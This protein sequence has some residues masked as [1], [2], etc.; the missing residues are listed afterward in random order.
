ME[1]ELLRYCTLL[2][3]VLPFIVYLVKI[4]LHL[5]NVTFSLILLSLFLKDI[6]HVSALFICRILPKLHARWFT[7]DWSKY[8]SY[9]A[10]NEFHKP[11]FFSSLRDLCLLPDMHWTKPSSIFMC[12]LN[13]TVLIFGCYICVQS[14][15]C[16]YIFGDTTSPARIMY[17]SYLLIWVASV[18][19]KISFCISAILVKG[20]LD[21]VHHSCLVFN[22]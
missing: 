3:F 13:R 6:T 14:D 12:F 22:L 20:Y 18:Q 9:S 1:K 19:F 7:D 17:R 11:F 16:S 8:V 2:P 5:W 10:N 4:L 15:L 21:M